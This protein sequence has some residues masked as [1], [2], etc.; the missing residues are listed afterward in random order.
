MFLANGTGIDLGQ[1]LHE[2]AVEDDVVLKPTKEFVS[3]VEI[4][5]NDQ[6]KF[7]FKI[8]VSTVAAI[9]TTDGIYNSHEENWPI[10]QWHQNYA[11]IREVFKNLDDDPE[12]I[13][14]VNLPVFI[15]VGTANKNLILTTPDGP[16]I[17]P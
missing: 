11:K 4:S 16:G 17:S 5:E 8:F 1:Y 3:E 7:P 14:L 13:R 15:H 6:F 9:L 10:A 2:K 12:L